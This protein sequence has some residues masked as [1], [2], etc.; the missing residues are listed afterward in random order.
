MNAQ[1]VVHL[2]MYVCTHA[3]GVRCT[4]IL[5]L[6][7]M[8]C[9]RNRFRSCVSKR[10]LFYIERTPIPMAR[11]LRDAVGVVNGLRRVAVAYSIEVSRELG[12]I[13][14]RVP[15]ILLNNEERAGHGLPDDFPGWE[16]FTSGEFGLGAEYN[17]PVSPPNTYHPHSTYNADNQTHESRPAPTSATN[18]LNGSQRSFHTVAHH[19]LVL[20]QMKAF[21]VRHSI[22]SRRGAGIRCVTSGD[23]VVGPTTGQQTRRR[24]PSVKTEESHIEQQQKVVIVLCCR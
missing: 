24:R 5:R 20:G 3:Q 1:E 16:N 11:R 17:S 2:C 12:E 9:M 13:V 6:W 18:M 8:I 10:N 23:T 7:S 15:A 19:G 21:K 14:N 22:L 4:L